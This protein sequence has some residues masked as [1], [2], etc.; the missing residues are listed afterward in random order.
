[1]K[2]LVSLFWVVLFLSSCPLFDDGSSGSGS[3][4]GIE[5]HNEMA[6]TYIF[7][8]YIS[9]STDSSWGEDLLGNRVI[10]PYE[11]VFFPLSTGSWDIWVEDEDGSYAQLYDISITAGEVVDVYMDD[12]TLWYN[13]LRRQDSLVQPPL[14][15][16]NLRKSRE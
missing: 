8:V 3:V 11:S 2:K 6:Y 5:V 12:T 14:K 1:M 15:G 16:Q 10:P 13:V 7:W 9:A 4:Q